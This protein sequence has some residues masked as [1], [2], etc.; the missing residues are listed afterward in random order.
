MSDMK[1]YAL[2]VVSGLEEQAKRNIEK[3]LENYK[4]QDRVGQI[5]IPKQT[6]IQ[7]KKGKRQSV[8]TNL[9]QGY[10]L[11]QADLDKELIHIIKNSPKVKK[12][13]GT[14][15][16]PIPLEDSE[17]DKLLRRSE[18]K[19]REST[20]EIDLIKGEE[21]KIIIGPFTDFTGT[22]DDINMEKSSLKVLVKIFGRATA[23]DLKF[24][25]IVKLSELKE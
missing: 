9:F 22:I 20:A 17:V 25:Q 2:Y 16:N 21:V 11:I 23:V 10:I 7:I 24:D 5:L 12:F 19:T 6:Q 1:W 14:Y 8:E 3:N 13:A 4:L 15:D 18:K